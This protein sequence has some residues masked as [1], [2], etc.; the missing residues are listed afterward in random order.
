M[1]VFFTAKIALQTA[2]II[3][4]GFKAARASGEAP[5]YP[6]GSHTRAVLRQCRC[7]S[8]LGCQPVID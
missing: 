8:R 4:P 2:Q 1:I 7:G 6:S 3:Q 5:T